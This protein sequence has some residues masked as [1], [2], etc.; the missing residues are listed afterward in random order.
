MGQSCVVKETQRV[1]A[2]PQQPDALGG[3]EGGGADPTDAIPGQSEVVG[4]PGESEWDP[5]QATVAQVKQLHWTLETAVEGELDT[6]EWIAT[7]DQVLE[8]C[9]WGEGVSV[10]R[11]QTIGTEVERVQLSVTSKSIVVKT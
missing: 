5:D 2:Q 11:P 7:Q 1:F 8:Q 9:E 3:V 4:D 6:P 10:D